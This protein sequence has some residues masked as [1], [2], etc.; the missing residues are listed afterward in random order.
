MIL[1]W[2]GNFFYCHLFYF[3][4]DW[5]AAYIEFLFI[6]SFL[7][8]CFAFLLIILAPVIQPGPNCSICNHCRFNRLGRL[9]SHPHLV[10]LFL[11]QHSKS[12][13]QTQKTKIFPFVLVSDSDFVF[14]ILILSSL[15][16]HY[17]G[18]LWAKQ[19]KHRV[20]IQGLWNI[21]KTIETYFYLILN[22]DPHTDSHNHTRTQVDTFDR[23][24][25]ILP[26]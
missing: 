10:D 15:F 20:W 23:F 22:I 8:T 3:P 26:Y 9:H 2:F 6:H 17:I 18:K 4:A 13:I 24:G 25:Y 11:L 19:P 14:F 1:F 21:E 5:C 12:R 7:C 16:D